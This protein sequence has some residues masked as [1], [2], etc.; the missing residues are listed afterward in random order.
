MDKPAKKAGCPFLCG[1]ITKFRT[2]LWKICGRLKSFFVEGCN[3]I[4]MGLQYWQ[5]DSIEDV[6]A[7][8]QTLV[9]SLRTNIM[10]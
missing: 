5:F 4:L 9:Y 2:G 8:A 1:R 6:V 3:P 10:R 7:Y